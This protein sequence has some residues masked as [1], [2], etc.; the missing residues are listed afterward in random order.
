[1]DKLSWDQPL[2]DPILQQYLRLRAQLKDLEKISLQRKVLKPA[3]KSDLQ[4]HVF[5]DHS[6]TAYAA[7]VFIR[8]ETDNFIETKMLTAK[9]RVA[10]IKSVCVPRLEI[11]AALLR[12]KLVEAVTNAI[13]DERFPTPKVFAWSDSTVTIAWLQDYPRKWKTFVANRVAKIQEI[14]PASS[15]KYVPTEDNPADCA[16][17]G[18]AAADLMNHKLWWDGPEWLRQ[19]E[20]AWPSLDILSPTGEETKKEVKGAI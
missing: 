6:T 7:V 14:I 1:M 11:C 20:N 4:L 12:A 2:S 5:C 8:Q 19:P 18:L 9:T 15:W 3:T 13:S 10:P 17:R 16:S